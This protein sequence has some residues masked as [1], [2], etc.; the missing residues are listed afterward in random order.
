MSLPSVDRY[1]TDLETI[2]LRHINVQKD[3]IRL[4]AVECLHADSP[5]RFGDFKSGGFKTLPA[6][7]RTVGSSSQIR[8][9]EMSLLASEVSGSILVGLSSGLQ[10]RNTSIPVAA[11]TALPDLC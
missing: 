8:I 2:H 1:C 7:S 9:F 10:V 5:S 6:S 11:S 4:F 3:Q